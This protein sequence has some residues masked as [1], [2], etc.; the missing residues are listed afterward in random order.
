MTWYVVSSG[1]HATP[2][3]TLLLDLTVYSAVL[4]SLMLIVSVSIVPLAS[5]DHGTCTYSLIAHQSHHLMSLLSYS[6]HD[7]YEHI[8]FEPSTDKALYN[9]VTARTRAVSS[10]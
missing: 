8:F 2:T 5:N 10:F 7:P 6:S 1:A 3:A 9:R 4:L